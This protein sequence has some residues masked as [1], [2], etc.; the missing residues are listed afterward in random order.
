MTISLWK[1]YPSF[2]GEAKVS[3]WIYRIVLNT[4]ITGY[5]QDKRHQR[6][7]DLT[8]EEVLNLPDYPTDDWSLEVHLLY[9]AIQKL[10]T[11]DKA[12]ILLYL[13]EKSYQEISIII[14]IGTAAVGMRI[15]R[16]KEKLSILLKTINL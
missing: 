2:R 9:S 13:E 4:A 8:N 15:K 1:A 11:I 3:T 12:I 6:K 10:S 5:R 14:G 16:I 7:V